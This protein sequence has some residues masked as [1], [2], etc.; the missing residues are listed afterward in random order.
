MI[1]AC[2]NGIIKEAK[3]NGKEV[4]STEIIEGSNY[5]TLRNPKTGAVFKTDSVYKA[6][7]FNLGIAED[8]W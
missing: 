5:I 6:N 4:V 3:R 1:K 7:N 8:V 2:L